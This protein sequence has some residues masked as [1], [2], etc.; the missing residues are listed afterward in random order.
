[1]LQLPREKPVIRPD[2]TAVWED[3]YVRIRDQ[4]RGERAAGMRPRVG[5]R[6]YSDRS[7][8]LYSRKE[9]SRRCDEAINRW[10]EEIEETAR[11]GKL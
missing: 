11:K 2:W 9:A 10:N 5:M 8:D 1:M 3:H 7:V 4:L 6:D